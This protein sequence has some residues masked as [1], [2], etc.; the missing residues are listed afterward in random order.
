[1]TAS[2]LS[3]AYRHTARLFIYEIPI[4]RLAI[5]SRFFM[6][7]SPMVSTCDELK[8]VRLISLNAVFD[9][10]VAATPT[11]WSGHAEPRLTQAHMDS[12]YRFSLKVVLVAAIFLIALLIAYLVH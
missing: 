9:F 4:L 6:A 3:R 12:V 10:E 7:F 2:T 11:W 5:P 1:M 8:P